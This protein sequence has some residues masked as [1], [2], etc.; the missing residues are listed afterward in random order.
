[1]LRLVRLHGP[2]VGSQGQGN[3]AGGA[4]RPVGIHHTRTRCADGER[5]SRDYQNGKFGL[6]FPPC[7]ELAEILLFDNFFVGA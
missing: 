3:Q 7:D 4:E 5:L 1:M 2:A 6:F